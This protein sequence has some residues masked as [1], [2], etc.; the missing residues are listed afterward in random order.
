MP[1]RVLTVDDSPMFLEVLAA[2][3]ASRPGIQV[4]GAAR[5][6][7]EAVEKALALAP[8]VVTLDVEM[9]VMDGLA[10]L[11]RLRAVCPVPV[12]MVSSLT[13]TASETTIKALQG[14]AADFV[15]KPSS[16][17]RES[18]EALRLEILEKLAAV[19]ARR[20]V[21]SPAG[22]APPEGAGRPAP[23]AARIAVL[24]ASTGGAAAVTRILESLPAR[25]GASIIVVQHMP[26]VF[27]EAFARSLAATVRC[28]VSLA[29]DGD[30]VE[31]GRVFIAPGG[32]HCAVYGNT[33]R[34]GDG[35]P[36]NGHCPSVDVTM[37]SAA[38]RFGADCLGVLLTGI[39][40]DGARGMADIRAAGGATLAQDEASCVVFGMPR[41]AIA[42]GVVDAV[43]SLDG[44]CAR[45]PA[46]VGA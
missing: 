20:T 38:R 21:A 26:G 19:A 13:R 25:V 31:P 9:P 46:L 27:T 36:V 43:L 10:T 16:T 28:P 18:Y 5:D 7:R 3:C 8:D 41:A 24:G 30:V 44:L 29:A 12:I 45:L 2:I 35:E 22:G 11:Q 1:I 14:G 42:D 34:V 37:R 15:T 6:G 39:G 23:R 33:F 4:V 32:R 40:R 17:L